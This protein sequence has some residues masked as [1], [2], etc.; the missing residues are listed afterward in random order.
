MTEAP[1][2]PSRAPLVVLDTMV[3][4]RAVVG[5]RDAADALVLRAVATGEVRLA[6]SDDGLRELQRVMNY[7]FVREKIADPVRAFTVGLDVGVMG[8]LFHPESST[9]PLCPTPRIVGFSTSPSKRARTNLIRRQSLPAIGTS[10]TAVPSLRPWG[11]ESSPRS[12]SSRSSVGSH[13][14][15]QPRLGTIPEA[16]ALDVRE[17]LRG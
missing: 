7:D 5:R 4:I 9:G 16:K 11:S 14:Q 2:E 6:I 13:D 17:I 3:V 1:A 12:S 15:S 8:K 10:W